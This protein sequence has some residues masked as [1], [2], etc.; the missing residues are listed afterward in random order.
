M[1]YRV[2]PFLRSAAAD[3]HKTNLFAMGLTK[4]ISSMKPLHL[5]FLQKKFS[6]FKKSFLLIRNSLSLNVNYF[7]AF[8]VCIPVVH[9]SYTALCPFGF[10]YM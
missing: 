9:C 4:A 2:E 5:T 1:D 8:T 6:P 7:Y 3:F 10:A